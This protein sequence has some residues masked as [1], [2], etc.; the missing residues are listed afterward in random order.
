MRPKEEWV[1]FVKSGFSYDK[2]SESLARALTYKGD[3]FFSLRLNKKQVY[4]RGFTRLLGLENILSKMGAIP[5]YNEYLKITNKQDLDKAT[6]EVI[7]RNC[8][9][10]IRDI[11]TLTIE[12][13]SALNEKD[14]LQNKLLQILLRGL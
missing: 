9:I 1:E 8:V 11:E 6:V 4:T 12:L 7:R 14:R 2:L 5:R 13:Q 10:K 3:L